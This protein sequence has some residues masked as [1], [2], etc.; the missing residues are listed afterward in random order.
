NQ[1]AAP[2]LT[3]Q[4]FDHCWYWTIIRRGTGRQYVIDPFL[5]E[6]TY[7]AL[8]RHCRGQFL[9]QLPPFTRICKFYFFQREGVDKNLAH[10]LQL[11]LFGLGLASL[12]ASEWHCR[13]LERV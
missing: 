8:K 2:F 3:C 1:C 7:T 13:R 6:T 11:E 10:L 4:T 9:I 12:Q 5:I